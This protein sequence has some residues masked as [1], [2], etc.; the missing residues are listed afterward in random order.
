MSPSLNENAIMVEVGGIQAVAK[1][2]GL[3][4]PCVT[5]PQSLPAGQ[6]RSVM[7]N[8]SGCTFLTMGSL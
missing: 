7:L 2:K 5:S 8:E 3:W 1:S 6:N 4:A